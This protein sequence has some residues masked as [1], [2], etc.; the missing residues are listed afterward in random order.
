MLV[1]LQRET[2]DLLSSSFLYKGG[3]NHQ[4]YV[5]EKATGPLFVRCWLYSAGKQ[6]LQF[7]L[8]LCM[9]AEERTGSMHSCEEV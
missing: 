3:G 6:N 1:R 2:L 5:T 9:L 7:L 4:L 8:F